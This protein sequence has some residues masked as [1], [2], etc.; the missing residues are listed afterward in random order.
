MNFEYIYIY[1]LFLY[2]NDLEIKKKKTMKC[3][4]R[5]KRLPTIF[6]FFLASSLLPL[7]FYYMWGPFVRLVFSKRTRT[8]MKKKPGACSRSCC[9]LCR[10]E[11]SGSQAATPPWRFFFSLPAQQSFLARLLQCHYWRT[12][13]SL[14]HQTTLQ[15]VIQ[16]V[17]NSSL[18]LL[19]FSPI[20]VSAA[21]PPNRM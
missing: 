9:C 16:S 1:I 21:P 19:L 3:S 2:F 20:L 5:P 15:L 13:V 14:C 18:I 10:L 7:C 11:R 17:V 6:F 4:S 12:S 8:T